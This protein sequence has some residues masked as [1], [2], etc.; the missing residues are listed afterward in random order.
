MQSEH[1]DDATEYTGNGPQGQVFRAY[2]VDEGWRYGRFVR[3]ITRG[4]KAGQYVL[5]FAKAGG[6]F[7]NRTFQPYEVVCGCCGLTLAGTKAVKIAGGYAL[8]KE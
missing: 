1:D 2:T 7:K 3:E 6:G 5:Q 4:K 8:E